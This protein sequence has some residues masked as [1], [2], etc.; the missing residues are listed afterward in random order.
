MKRFVIS[1]IAIFSLAHPSFGDGDGVLIDGIRKNFHNIN[2]I[3]KNH[4]TKVFTFYTRINEESGE[5]DQ[6]EITDKNSAEYNGDLLFLNEVFVYEGKII[7][8]IDQMDFRDSYTT[9]YYF[10]EKGNVFFIYQLM[11]IGNI[12]HPGSGVLDLSEKEAEEDERKYFDNGEWLGHVIVERRFYFD[13]KQVLIKKNVNSYRKD[14]KKEFPLRYVILKKFDV[15]YDKIDAEYNTHIC[16]VLPKEEIDALFSTGRIK[17]I[18]CE[19]KHRKTPSPL[20]W[21]DT[22]ANLKIAWSE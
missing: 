12:M 5:S 1:A 9:E 3:I 8:I 16:F 20:Q 7:K 11:D 19:K 15:G 10:N 17:K 4:K 2:G 18:S 22:R 14:N 13:E 21:E 6:V